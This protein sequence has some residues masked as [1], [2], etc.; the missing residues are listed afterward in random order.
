M[1]YINLFKKTLIKKKNKKKKIKMKI[2][3]KIINIYFL[4]YQVL[5]IYLNF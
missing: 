4:C 5:I 3:K 2:K 1:K